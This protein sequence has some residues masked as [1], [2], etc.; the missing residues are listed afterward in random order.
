LPFVLG[1]A[2]TFECDEAHT[3]LLSAACIAGEILASG[4]E[5]AIK[6]QAV[7][8]TFEYLNPGHRVVMEILY[9]G[10]R[11]TVVNSALIGGTIRFRRYSEPISAVTV[12]VP[13]LI[14]TSLLLLFVT[15]GVGMVV[16]LSRHDPAPP[17]F[18]E[19]FLVDGTFWAVNVLLWVGASRFLSRFTTTRMQHSFEEFLA[20][21]VA[22][23]WRPDSRQ[24]D[25]SQ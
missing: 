14:G 5:C 15:G 3:R 23:T 16:F 19:A 2:V 10:A 1:S 9:S 25:E 18:I 8:F 22:C 21:D 20:E 17:S 7:E 11:P 12:L 6:S 24:S 4:A 13:P